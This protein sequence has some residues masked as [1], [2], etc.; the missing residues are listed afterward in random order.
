MSV[1]VA[2][3]DETTVDVEQWGDFDEAVCDQTTI[4]ASLSQT[5]SRISP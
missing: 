4:L 2:E 1:M 3:S 5:P